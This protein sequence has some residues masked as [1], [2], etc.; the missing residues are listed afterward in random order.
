M[1]V[2]A[3]AFG[4]H[5]QAVR[6]FG[7]VQSIPAGGGWRVHSYLSGGSTFIVYKGVAPI[8]YLVIGGGGGSGGSHDDVVITAGGGA[9]GYRSSVQGENTGGGLPAEEPLSLLSGIYSVSVGAGGV[10]GGSGL[11][12]G[13]NGASSSFGPIIAVGGGRGG[14]N[15]NPAGAEG[16]SGGGGSPGNGARGAGTPGQGFAGGRGS[17]YGTTN[18][19]AGGGGG[20][21]S[22]GLPGT[23]T[24]QFTK[25]SVSTAT[26][27][28]VDL[29]APP[30]IIDGVTLEANMRV[31]VKNQET[32]SQNG[33]YVFNGTSLARATD[34]DTS[35]EALIGSYVTVTGGSTQSGNWAISATSDII[36][37][38]S[39]AIDWQLSTQAPPRGGNGGVG[40]VSSITG[41]SI[42]RG[43]GGGGSGA[44]TAGVG[45]HGGA[46]GRTGVASAV[47]GSPNTGGGAGGS[48]FFS[49]DGALAS[50]SGAAGG[51]GV[52]IVR[53]WI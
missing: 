38:G 23:T 17:N 45:V 32:A 24:A 1:P 37:L 30:G 18:N 35:G 47:G 9:G 4:N 42:G 8:E 46:T 12:I 15:P 29:S 28:S 52:V 10:G 25:S 16:G 48:A 27:E 40:I 26:T 21:S 14:A 51:S 53:Y 2:P 36:T 13:G 33:I 20:A 43:G 7:G 19:G 50:R 34:M 6:A 49:T 31:L 44:V 41:V 5:N 39:S 3:G 22:R 11:T